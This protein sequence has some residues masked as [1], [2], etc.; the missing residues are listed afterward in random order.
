MLQLAIALFLISL[1]HRAAPI[2]EGKHFL[3]YRLDDV[4]QISSQQI[5][6]NP[7]RSV[8]ETPYNQSVP[9]DNG[10]G[11]WG[12]IELDFTNKELDLVTRDTIVN[13]NNNANLFLF[14][15]RTV[16]A[17]VEDVRV[18][19]VG[20]QRGFVRYVAIYK[21]SGYV[22]VEILVA[23]YNTVRIFVEIFTTL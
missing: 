19:N 14:Y 18:Y 15:N 20:R 5:Q 10:S 9:V 6:E 8:V 7:K 4:S 12:D 17:Y 11:T 16:P 1:C 23:A 2:Y 13:Q 22:E 3:A 21:N